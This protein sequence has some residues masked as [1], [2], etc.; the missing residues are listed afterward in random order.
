[1]DAKWWQ[2][3]AEVFIKLYIEEDVRG[4]DID[5]E[6]HPT[7]MCLKVGGAS[8]LEGNYEEAGKINIEGRVG[9]CEFFFLVWASC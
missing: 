3:P 8:L 2:S 6:L 5:F 1:M 7:R 4:R 9:V